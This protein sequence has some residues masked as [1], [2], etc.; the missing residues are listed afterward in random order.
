MAHPCAGAADR[1][2]GIVLPLERGEPRARP[3]ALPAGRRPARRVA[4][5]RARSTSS[6]ASCRSTRSFEAEEAGA[7]R[8][9]RSGTRRV[10]DG[11]RRRVRGRIVRTR[12]GSWRSSSSAGRGAALIVVVAVSNRGPGARPFS[13]HVA[14][15]SWDAPCRGAGRTAAPGA[16]ERAGAERRALRAQPA[17][18]VKRALVGRPLATRRA[19]GDPPPQDARAADLRVR[20]ALVGRLRDRGRARRPDRRPRSA[21]AISC[22]RSRSRSPRC[23]R[24][25]SSRTGRPSAPTSRAAAPTSSRRTTSAR[26]PPRRCRG[27]AHRLRAH[28]RRLGRGRHLRDHL[29]RRRRS[30]PHKVALGRWP[31]SSSLFAREPARPARVRACF[32]AADLRVRRG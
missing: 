1:V 30:S 9:A 21:A 14:R 19:G 15:S 22:C 27:A 18:T 13:V 2:P 5:A 16:R 8:R 12:A 7:R 23:S 17:R 25:S 32:R 31:A 4:L 11:L 20:P 24:S 26:L 10:A 3:V 6:A 29:L 28:G